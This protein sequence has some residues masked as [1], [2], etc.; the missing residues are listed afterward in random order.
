LLQRGTVTFEEQGALGKYFDEAFKASEVQNVTANHASDG[1]GLDAPV[2]RLDAGLLQSE[3]AVLKQKLADAEQALARLK[4]MPVVRH[5]KEDQDLRADHPKPAVV[6]VHEHDGGAMSKALGSDLL[7]DALLPTDGGGDIP[8]SVS[9]AAHHGG[10]EGHRYVA[11]LFFFGVLGIGCVILLI[12]E[13]VAPSVP[14]TCALFVAGMLVSMVHNVKPSDSIIHWESW[15]NSVEMWQ[16]IDPHILFYTFLPPLLFGEAMSLNV[17][18]AS[19]CFAQVVILACPG[20]LLGTLLIATVAVYILPYGWSW[21]IALLFGSVLS[22]TDPVAVVA[23]FN[24]LGV[25]PRLTMLIAGESLLNDGTAIVIFALMLK[26]LLGATLTAAGVC[27]F[28]FNMVCTAVLF[29]VCFGLVSLAMLGFTSESRRHSDVMIQVIVTVVC[30]YISFFVAESELSASGVLATVSAGYMMSSYAWPRFVERETVHVVWEAIEF[31]GNTVIFFL[32]GTIFMDTVLE[33][34]SYIGRGDLFWLLVLYVCLLLIRTLMIGVLWL[35]LN[36]AGSELHWKEGVVMVWSG[37]RGAVSLTLA[38]IIDL[39]PAVSKQMGTRVMFHVGGIAALTFLV[40]ATTAASLL[41]LL[42]LA[43]TSTL[44]ERMLDIFAQTVTDESISVFAEHSDGFGDMRFNGAKPELVRAMVP[45]LN[46]RALDGYQK[47][48]T[49]RRSI[50]LHEDVVPSD[51][52]MP[53]KS[54]LLQAYREVFMKLVKHRYWN[55]VEAGIIPRNWKVSGALLHATDEALED[56]A[57]PLND[58]EVLTKG[59][60][61]REPGPFLNCMASLAECRPFKF[62]PEFRSTYSTKFQTLHKAWLAISFID[63]HVHAQKK[64]PTHFDGNDVTTQKVAEQVEQESSSECHRAT[65]LLEGMDP[66]WVQLAKSLMFAR[67]LLQTQ[68][69]ELEHVSEKGI[70]DAS[71]VQCMEQCIVEAMREITFANPSIWLGVAR[72]DS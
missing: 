59:N 21:P 16:H 25:S 43:G 52:S 7:G 1:S 39:E 35:P 19:K 66:E 71:E 42:G 11:L 47:V 12:I 3:V 29:G 36:L 18:L 70:L 28:F 57:T 33:R 13:R 50:T 32:A 26:V 8:T 31:V 72:G 63:A 61:L 37:L 20:V 58:W 17:K 54:K 49:R 15:F 46:G 38:I 34:W 55:A 40:N 60:I 51:S 64:A 45:A 24:T 68:L 6:N 5:V 56:S 41:R 44:K 23:L 30:S 2:A 67:K 48:I 65:E 22:A 27:S 14:Y 9:H 10:A 69:G 53:V 62:L 4:D